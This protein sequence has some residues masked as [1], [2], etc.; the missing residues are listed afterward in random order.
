MQFLSQSCCNKSKSIKLGK[1]FSNLSLS[2]LS[3]EVTGAFSSSD[4]KKSCDISSER[5]VCFENKILNKNM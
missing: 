1:V 2:R 5:R 3:H 4:D